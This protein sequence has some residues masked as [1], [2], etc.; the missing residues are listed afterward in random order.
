MQ[1]EVEKTALWSVRGIC[2]SFPGVRAL[3]DVSLNIYGGEVHALL[4]ENGSGKSTLAKCLAGVYFPDRGEISYQGSPVVFHSPT[5]AREKGIATIYQ[6]FSIVP[7]LTVAENV[8]L[9]NYKTRKGT[10]SIDWRTTRAD[11]QKVL[12]ELC[13]ELDPDAVVKNL[14]C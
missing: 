10:G 11:T 12:D 6:E 13:L 1:L 5:E 9:G 2:K 8:F 7:T 4:G 3:D 14:S